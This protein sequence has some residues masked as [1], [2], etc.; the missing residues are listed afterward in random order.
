MRRQLALVAAATT[1]LV[2]LAL[3]I[4]LIR[5]VGTI[6]RDRAIANA[7]L[8]SQSLAQ[9]ITAV[10]N[11][12]RL[13]R[14]VAQTSQLSGQPISIVLPSGESLGAPVTRTKSLQQAEAGER[15]L[16][17]LPKSCLKARK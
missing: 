12:Q 14:L 11:R 5:A 13:D 17:Y 3:L 15:V 8:T 6:P 2:V 4:P 10:P 16:S 7:Q 9:T 1:S